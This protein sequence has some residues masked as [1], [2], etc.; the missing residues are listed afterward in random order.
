M[1]ILNN[2]KTSVKLIGSFLIIAILTGAVG[3]IGIYYLRQ[4]AAADI[5][6]YEH[7]TVPISQLQEIAVAFQRTRVNLRDLILS[8]SPEESQKYVDTIK[9]LSTDIDKVQAEYEALIVSQEMRTLFDDYTKSYEEFIPFRDQIMSL[10]LAD[11]Q[12]EALTLMRGDAVA[13]AKAVEA[14]IDA[15]VAMKADQAKQTADANTAEAGQATTI[16]IIFAVVTVL[17][18]IGLGVIISRSISAPLGTLTNMAE[19][20]S[21]GNLVREVSDQ[22]K[23]KVR[24]RRDEIGTIGQAFDGLISY[25]QNMSVAA[26]TIADNDLTI[27]VTPKSEKDELGNAFAKM[28]AGLRSVIG[29]VAES[30]GTVSAAASQL[31]SASDQSG[32]A[33]NQIATTI[34][35]VAAGTTQQSEEVAR[36]PVRWSRWDVLSKASP[37]APRNKPR[38]LAKHPKSQ[39]ELIPPSSKLLPTLSLLP[40]ILPKL[41]NN[42]A[43]ALRPSRKRS[44]AWKASA[45]K[46]DCPPPKWKRWAIV[47]VRLA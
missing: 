6:T 5:E 11:K 29:Q 25:M 31:A 1:N 8:K 9:E 13:T 3:T 14:N 47:P 38:R 46:W 28:I 16:M 43:M 36:H 2:L 40:A 26:A 19:A 21:V 18:G 17:L 4:I 37:K 42:L 12:D 10:A 20:L 24:L 22:E 41:Q 44:R 39:P 45:R 15:M 27:S 7:E 30:A 34:Q 35:Q 23:D 33:T 32:K